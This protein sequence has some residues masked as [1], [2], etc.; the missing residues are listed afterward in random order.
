M[1]IM[2]INE[3]PAIETK[4]KSSSAKNDKSY[5]EVKAKFRIIN[6]SNKKTHQETVKISTTNKK[7]T[8][9]EETLKNDN[10]TTST[11]AT[12]NDYRNSVDK[13]QKK[14]KK[15]KLSNSKLTL[16]IENSNDFK[17]DSKKDK[18]IEEYQETIHTI[19]NENSENIITKPVINAEGKSCTV[20]ISIEEAKMNSLKSKGLNEEHDE[21][22]KQLSCY[23][24]KGKKDTSPSIM[25]E[26]VVD[27]L[28]RM[29]KYVINKAVK[30]ELRRKK[31]VDQLL[32]NN[33]SKPQINQKSK[34]LV[35][36]DFK[37]RQEDYKT[38]SSK[39]KNDLFNENEEKI[40]R[41]M[42]PDISR[43]KGV[44]SYKT[45]ENYINFQLKWEIDRKLKIQ[46]FRDK[47][48]HDLAKL[49]TFTPKI[50][51]KSEII[52]KTVNKEAVTERL[53]NLDRLK[54][55]NR[56]MITIDD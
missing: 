5:K 34:T 13:M 27:L 25:P 38:I 8:I 14:N 48:E 29:E 18:K 6:E 50:S 26:K 21:N 31:L 49:C 24:K 11:V 54:L 23:R 30:L 22:N 36:K 15:R 39:L 12:K 3:S 33:F 2:K 55:R 37:N 17:V 44:E 46:S 56:Y 20:K 42:T 40:I 41:E 1:N 10:K 4:N 47:D 19:T 9:I 52:A 51:K 32:S 53:Y 45:R 35:S 16:K 43:N 28:D 7:K